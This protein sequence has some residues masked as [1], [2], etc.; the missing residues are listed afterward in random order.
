MATL[1]EKLAKI[2]KLGLLVEASRY[3]KQN[4]GSADRKELPDFGS[5]REKIR[6]KVATKRTEAGSSDAAGANTRLDAR[7]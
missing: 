3:I 1:R 5:I 2:G 6:M 4:A 7:L